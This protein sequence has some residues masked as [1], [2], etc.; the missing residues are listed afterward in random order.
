MLLKHSA[1]IETDWQTQPYKSKRG[2]FRILFTL[3]RKKGGF[4][5]LKMQYM[6]SS[7]VINV[8]RWGCMFQVAALKGHWQGE[9]E[10]YFEAAGEMC[11]HL[12]IYIQAD[13]P[14][15]VNNFTGAH[16]STSAGKYHVFQ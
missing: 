16:F 3:R 14:L 8:L 7:V 6:I 15:I 13:L 5:A 1:C 12:A 9:A 4:L 10:C 2:P 11:R